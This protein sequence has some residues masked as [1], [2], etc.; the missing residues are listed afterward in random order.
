MS[1]LHHSLHLPE[2]DKDAFWRLICFAVVST[3]SW[4]YAPTSSLS[5]GNIRFTDIDYA[6]DAVLFAEGPDKWRA[7]LNSFEAAGGSMGLHPKWLKTKIQNIG[8]GPTPD[9][10]QM[11]NQTVDAVTKFTYLGS[12][13]DSEGYSTP[14]IHRRIGMANSIMGQLDS[15]WK[16]QSLS[17]QTRL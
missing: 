5:V 1:C 13:V 3:G 8:A 4:N 12:D 2:F 16:E 9:S 14:E 7:V 11:G 10:V 15:R 17:V 6:D